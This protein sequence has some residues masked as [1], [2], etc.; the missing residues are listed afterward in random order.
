MPERNPPTPSL[1]ISWDWMKDHSRSCG[2]HL[3]IPSEANFFVSV[4]SLPSVFL[5]FSSWA[6]WSL[7][8]SSYRWGPVVPSCLRSTSG[9]TTAI[10]LLYSAKLYLQ[11]R[12]Q[13]GRAEKVEEEKILKKVGVKAS[14]P[15]RLGSWC[16]CH[17]PFQ[18]LV[19]SFCT[20]L[21]DLPSLLEHGVPF[22][23]SA[24]C[25]LILLPPETTMMA[26]EWEQN[27]GLRTPSHIHPSVW[28]LPLCQNGLCGPLRS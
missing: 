9:P 22:S 21:R 10:P 2:S 16:M 24:V 8:P 11:D 25:L 1:Q 4:P 17:F 13:D 23:F 3:K 18:I 5:F 12:A 15:W 27:N 28:D 14:M 6:S 26:A 19:G 20:L 7:D